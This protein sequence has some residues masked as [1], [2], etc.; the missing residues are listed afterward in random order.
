MHLTALINNSWV[1]VLKCPLSVQL[2]FNNL[3][4]SLIAEL[5]LLS[6]VAPR[7]PA[8]SLLCKKEFCKVTV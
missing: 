5:K 7:S 3:Q 6:D 4:G 1:S 8:L 2:W